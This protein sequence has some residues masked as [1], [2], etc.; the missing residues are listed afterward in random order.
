MQ[1]GVGCMPC[2]TGAVSDGSSTCSA[3]VNGKEANSDQSDCNS[4]QPGYISKN[5]VAC[6]PCPAG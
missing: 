4:C 1:V 6:T 3:C 2:Q 5:G